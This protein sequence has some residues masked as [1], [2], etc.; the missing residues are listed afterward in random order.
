M[1]C[2][3]NELDN[4]ET[5]RR[6]QRRRP[7]RYGE[8]QPLPTKSA[9]ER[10]AWALSH[11]SRI[12][13]R[14]RLWGSIVVAL[15]WLWGRNRLAINTLCGGFDVALMWLWRSEEHTSELQSLR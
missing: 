2:P 13:H 5:G 11:A 7:K 8:H 9:H 10:L 3:A 15:G 4:A 14:S 12:T 1:Y 6:A